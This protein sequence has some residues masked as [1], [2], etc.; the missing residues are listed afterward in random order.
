MKKMFF[1]AIALVAF[2]ATSMA[3]TVE[4]KEVVTPIEENEEVM[5]KKSC[6]ETM[7]EIYEYIMDG[8]CGVV[9]SGC[10]GDN[11]ALLNELVSGCH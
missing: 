6:V 9:G 1:T 5:V 2:S 3:N 4:V 7:I 10:G 11:N 8:E